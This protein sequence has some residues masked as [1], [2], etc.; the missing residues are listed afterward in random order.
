MSAPDQIAPG[1]IAVSLIHSNTELT[2]IQITE[3]KLR[4]ALLEHLNVVESKKSWQLPL[5]L[6]LAVVPVL[7]TS[8]FRDT[9]GIDK[10]TWKAFFMFLS[11]ASGL[12]LLVSLRTAFV[13]TTIDGLV[14]KIKNAAAR[15]S[16]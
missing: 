9:A 6:L 13:S 11:A 1:H 10:T 8:D 3:D 12:W 5:G 4:L 15:G 7:L 14:G 2:L 16:A